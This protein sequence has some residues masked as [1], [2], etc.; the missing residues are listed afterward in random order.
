MTNTEIRFKK[1]TRTPPLGLLKLMLK[2]GVKLPMPAPTPL[3]ENWTEST[4]TK[5]MIF[6]AV[7]AFHRRQRI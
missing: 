1:A 2:M 7:A 5:N 6:Q 3:P 4:Q